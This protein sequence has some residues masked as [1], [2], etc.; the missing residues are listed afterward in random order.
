MFFR[1][2][3]KRRQNM[4]A[5]TMVFTVAFLAIT[6][7]AQ[8]GAVPPV[9]TVPEPSTLLMLGSGLATTWLWM[10]AKNRG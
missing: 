6:S 5:V 9:V 3:S 4:K 7:F 10:R 1:Q 8:A 2:K